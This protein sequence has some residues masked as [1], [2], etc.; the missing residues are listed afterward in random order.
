MQQ[1]QLIAIILVIAVVA[2]AAVGAVL[3]MKGGSS[4]DTKYTVTYNTNGGN[5]IAA[6]EFTK[7]T[8]T[9]DL[10]TP[11][12]DGSTFLGWYLNADFSGD[13]ITQ[14]AKGTEKNVTVYAKWQLNLA[15]NTLP[16]AAVITANTDVKVTFDSGASDKTISNDILDELKAGK[17]LTI[18]DTVSKVSWTFDG[19]ASKDIEYTAESLNTTVTVTETATQVNPQATLSFTHSGKLPYPSTVKYFFGTDFVGQNVTVKNGSTLEVLGPFTV[20]SEG[21]V[22]FEIDHCSPWTITVSY[23]VTFDANGGQIDGAGTKTIV[24]AHND[25]VGELP[26]PS[27]T[28]YDVYAWDPV[29]NANDVITAAKTYTA[30]WTANSYTV[31]YYKNAEDATGSVDDQP[32]QYGNL[33]ALSSGAGLARQG[34]TLSGWNT[35]TDG[36]GTAYD[37]AG[38]VS[39]LTAVNNG[40]F[41][42]YAQWTVNQYPATAIIGETA[43][44][45]NV[46]AGWT[47]NNNGSFT[48]NFNYGTSADDIIADFG[49]NAENTTLTGHTFNGMAPSQPTLGTT[50]MGIYALWNPNAYTV[51]FNANGASGTMSDQA[52]VYGTSQNLTANAFTH[53]NAAFNG[54]ATSATGTVVYA[55]Q[56]FVKDLTAENNAVI[57]LFAIWGPYNIVV[58]VTK[59]GAAYEGLAVTAKKDDAGNSLT[60]TYEGNGNYACR[61][62]IELSSSYTVYV[63][64]QNV[65]LVQTSAQGSGSSSVEYFTVTFD[66]NG[67]VPVD[68]I[69]VALRGTTVEEPQDMF[70]KTGNS[71]TSWKKGNADW[72]FSTAITETTTLVAQWTPQ[73][74]TVTLNTNGGTIN[75]G[76]VSQYTYGVAVDLPTDVTRDGCDFAGWYTNSQFSGD[77]VSAIA[78]GEFGNKE[79]FAKWNL[80]TYTITFNAQGGTPVDS[81]TY[82]IETQTFDLPTNTSKTGNHLNGWYVSDPASSIT[83]IVQGTHE[84]MALKANWVANTYTVTFN[85][86]YGAATGTME[87]QNMTYGTSAYLTNNGFSNE[88]FAFGG[89]ATTADGAKVY[90]N[91]QSVTNLTDVNEGNVNLYA[92]WEAYY[93]QVTVMVDNELD[94]SEINNMVARYNA[95]DIP[96]TRIS[97]GVYKV[98]NGPNTPVGNNVY[99]I[100]IGND[101]VTTV[102]VSDGVGIGRVI[103]NTVTFYTHCEIQVPAQKVLY[104]QCAQQPQMAER[105]GYDFDCWSQDSTQRVPF[106]FANTPI[107]AARVLDAFWNAQ[108]YTVIYNSNGGT[109]SMNNGSATFGEGFTPAACTFTKTVQ[110]VEYRFVCWNTAADGSGMVFRA[111]QG[112]NID[113]EAIAHVQAGNL[114]L[115]AMWTDSTYAAVVG[116]TFTGTYS[117]T[118]PN[119][120]MNFSNMPTRCVVISAGDE[121]RVEVLMQEQGNWYVMTVGTYDDGMWPVFGNLFDS[122]ELVSVLSGQGIADQQTINGQTTAITKYNFTLEEG[123]VT[124]YLCTVDETGMICRVYIQMVVSEQNSQA[125]GMGEGTY[126]EDIVISGFTSGAAPETHSVTYLPNRY[127]EESD[128]TVRSCSTYLTP[129]E[130]QFS[131][132]DK[133][134]EGWY[135]TDAMGDDRIK[136]VPGERVL[137]DRTVWAN[138]VTPNTNICWDV[139]NLLDEMQILLNGTADAWPQDATLNDYLTFPGTS[140]WSAATENNTYNFT[141]NQHSYKMYILPEAIG[142]NGNVFQCATPSIVDG[143]LRLTFGQSNPDGKFYVT[144]SIYDAALPAFPGYN[145]HVG[146]TFTYRSGSYDYTYTVTKIPGSEGWAY[147]DMYQYSATVMGNTSNY[148]DAMYVYPVA[149]PTNGMYVVSQ[150]VYDFNGQ[151][152]NCYIVSMKQITQ[153]S[154]QRATHTIVEDYVGI[155]DGLPY[156]TMTDMG[157][158]TTSYVL[159]SKSN[160]EAVTKHTV[161]FNGNG[162]KVD[163]KNTETLEVYGTNGINASREGYTFIG[164]ATAPDAAVTYNDHALITSDCT[165]YAKWDFGGA[166]LAT[167]GGN[168]TPSSPATLDLL[169][170]SDSIKVYPHSF[171]YIN[172]VQA[173]TTFTINGFMTVGETTVSPTFKYVTVVCINPGDINNNTMSQVASHVYVNTTMFNAYVSTSPEYIVLCVERNYTLTLDVGY[174]DK[175]DI[176]YHANGGTG[177]DIQT[178]GP[179][180]GAIVLKPSDTYS[181]ENYRFLGWATSSN[182][183]PM[184]SQ[185]TPYETMPALAYGDIDNGASVD[186][187]AIWEPYVHI[188]YDANGGTFEEPDYDYSKFV[189][190]D[191][192]TVYEISDGYFLHRNG[193]TLI[194]WSSDP[195]PVGE[196]MLKYV[197]GDKVTFPE[198]Q[199]GTEMILY[200]YWAPSEDTF[201]VYY[202]K[203]ANFIYMWHYPDQYDPLCLVPDVKMPIAQGSY[204]FANTP[205]AVLIGWNTAADGSGTAYG[206][207]GYIQVK[208]K[209][210]GDYV[211]YAMWKTTA[212]VHFDANGGMGYMADQQATF[213]S[214]TQLTDNAFT[215]EGST[216]A[217]WTIQG[218]DPGY[219]AFVSD[220]M[221]QYYLYVDTTYPEITLVANWLQQHTVTLIPNGGTFSEE[222]NT[223]HVVAHGAT[224]EVPEITKEDFNFFGWVFEDNE[225]YNFATTP[226][227]MNLTLNA[228]WVY[229]VYYYQWDQG[230]EE[231]VENLELR[232]NEAVGEIAIPAIEA[233]AHY[234]AVWNT[235]ADGSGDDV[236]PDTMYSLT[237]EGGETALY[238]IYRPLHMTVILDPDGGEGD[239][240]DLTFYYGQ[241]HMYLNV[242]DP[243]KEGFEFTG[244]HCREGTFASSGENSDV[245]ALYNDN[246]TITLTA[247]YQAA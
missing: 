183:I 195:N 163:G 130:L 238:E 197:G 221:G 143:N 124:G 149:A 211:L 25:T 121:Y 184:Q 128:G 115:Y 206:L 157:Y 174:D 236:E 152:V 109:G 177:Q 73:T 56:A 98:S 48:K 180:H 229:T 92:V 178:V 77:A 76:N 140:G 68:E 23:N 60:L 232:N 167:N 193:F 215:K 134:F 84:N 132:G 61:S 93:I 118:S 80:V 150:G 107:G 222:F 111:G 45:S 90:D 179:R 205:T 203:N 37:L 74:Y 52:F 208:Q 57:D 234:S 175:T 200:A 79:Y 136:Y 122:A 54:W 100:R 78:V 242:D 44:R 87:P 176:T 17:T 207:T 19:A 196:V 83:Q 237:H 212:T 191:G 58:N 161:T 230:E 105:A 49:S 36:S 220:I 247:Q 141:Y 123:A 127:S 154:G 15:N 164:W 243:Y 99:S 209:P 40:T 173:G 10:T 46:P 116:D 104:G 159:Q 194:G 94:P 190:A 3:L 201:S 95:Q 158:G 8:D 245:V 102:S 85:K 22:E 34:Y 172:G 146:D 153:A 148:S 231:W 125:M 13:K 112:T 114:T 217:G 135:Y 29:A 18:E 26:V 96:L 126:A 70:E 33:A 71:L 120:N 38:N 155:A 218:E 66:A 239:Y 214:N 216:F 81:I 228:R 64:T 169:N 166:H 63:G 202:D 86:N 55:D 185:G 97:T 43:I 6:K 59:D 101:E 16:D 181:K 67:G 65:G 106:D 187:Y 69:V 31:K 7:N 11:T 110:E 225:V 1:K 227:T 219:H 241:E 246:I 89:W 12:K 233:R 30:Q 103:Y 129:G 41:N 224:L 47:N 24:V 139:T 189:K 235:A 72:N 186:L 137:T 156:S 91:C 171:G 35:A 27:R 165:L 75:S 142:G 192:E 223:T 9:F 113:E 53:N 213:G 5:E 117:Y 138:W 2:A 168:G 210:Q 188:I 204:E 119:P 14:V 133:V 145:P 4:G 39:N 50:E 20:D 28:G 198:E 160:V 182:G 82:T 244:W 162:G 199:T 170:F 131:D 147:T 51:R 108:T 88:G 240:E 62:G 42:L 32:L 151:N 144:F 21:Y 226:V